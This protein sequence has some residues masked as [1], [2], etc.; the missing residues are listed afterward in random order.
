MDELPAG[1]RGWS[2]LAGPALVVR[3]IQR[4]VHRGGGLERG[5]LNVTLTVEQRREVGRLLGVDWEVSGKP[6]TLPALRSALAQHGLTVARFAELLHGGPLPVGRELRATRQEAEQ[7]ERRAVLDLF[8][9]AGLPG[10]VCDRW[11]SGARAP[12]LGTGRALEL[13]ERAAVVWPLLPWTGPPKRLAQL[14]AESTGD[15]HALDHST[16]L[17]RTVARLVAIAGGITPPARP[18]REWRAAW[19]SAGVRCDT[20][21]S[22]VLVLNVP[23]D[24]T[25]GLRG[26]TPVW[27]TLRDLLTPWSFTHPPR[28]LFVC[29]N[30]SVVEAAADEL[31]DL[32]PPLVCTDGMPTLAALDLLSG[33]AE[34]GTAVRARADI[35]SAGFSIL[36]T[37][38]SVVP[39]A[40]PWRFDTT[41]YASHFG[42]EGR[43]ASWPADLHAEHGKDL[44]EEAILPLLLADLRDNFLRP[45][46]PLSRGRVET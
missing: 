22:R 2:V 14:A 45:D 19:A 12:K 10:E 21:S 29:E 41:T 28:T 39:T 42:L 33:A 44:H 17:G 43:T 18:G 9:A 11:L 7:R 23:L 30:P 20:V 1:L 36:R 3:A 26:G 5:P 32:C 27:L 35:D 40:R 6:V 34:A 46:I 13:A 15:A 8:G 24:L 25:A 4:R 31:G 37:V 38:R 16:E